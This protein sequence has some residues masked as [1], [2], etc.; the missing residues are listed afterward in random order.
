MKPKASTV[1]FEKETLYDIEN[2][3]LHFKNNRIS[4]LE[5]KDE[6]ELENVL[7]K[8]GK[9][10]PLYHDIMNRGLQESL[11]LFPDSQIVAEGNCR[12]VC[13]R[14]LHREANETDE[15][16]LKKFKQIRVPCKRI[17]KGT[18]DA[19]VDAYLTEIHVGRKKKWPEYNQAQ[20][21]YK[22]KH[23]DNLPL[24]EI[25]QIARSSRPT[26]TRKIE[27]Y[28][29][30]KEYHKALPKDEDFIKKFYYFWE[31]LHPDLDKFR[32]NDSNIM[33]FMKWVYYG[34]FPTSKH[35]RDLPKILKNPKAFQT[36]EQ[37]DM[38]EAVK[39]MLKVDPTIRSPMY[40]KISNITELL[41][42]FPKNEITNLLGDES[43]KMMIDELRKSAVDL[44]KY[45]H[46]L[47]KKRD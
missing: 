30:T 24:E 13:L 34:K 28:K 44:L 16:A 23:R 22:L 35:I 18:S 41:S 6:N 27:C 36:F 39:I 14:K 5:I 25:A 19:D 11:V 20:L 29:L 38:E 2:L 47:E 8:E 4:H 12:L 21:L 31:F 17:V 9:L 46:D 26:V 10:Q 32:G 33:K 40:R 45:V 3:E 7:W 42:N 1:Q 37:T 43:K 15:P